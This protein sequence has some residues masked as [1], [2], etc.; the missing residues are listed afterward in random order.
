M[1]TV[2]VVLVVMM[3]IMI[4]YVNTEDNFYLT[5]SQQTDIYETALY[6]L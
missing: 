2:M 6:D 1:V 4:R 5:A 3:V